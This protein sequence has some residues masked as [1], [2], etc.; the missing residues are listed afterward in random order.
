[1]LQGLRSRTAGTP[2]LKATRQHSLVRFSIGG[3]VLA[4]RIDEVGD[5]QPWTASTFVPSQTPFIN[6]VV[7]YGNDFLP[8]FDLAGRLK[9]PTKSQAA[10]CMVAKHARGPIAVRI[11]QEIPSLQT[12]DEASI[13]PSPD[14]SEDFT[15]W[16]TMGGEEVSILSFAHIVTPTGGGSAPI[17]ERIEVQ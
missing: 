1:M 5:V 2:N 7:R 14:G 4:A 15:G 12:V 11:D 8:V 6:A 16:C 10:F 9:L 17:P 3:R 13:G